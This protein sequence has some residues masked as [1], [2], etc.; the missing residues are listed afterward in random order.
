MRSL[1]SDLMLSM[2][3]MKK[4]PG[5]TITIIAVLTLGVGANTAIFSVIHGVLLHPFPYRDSGRIVFISE[6]P[7][8]KKGQM[9]VT[10][11][12]YIDLR[13]QVQDFTDV[14]FASNRDFTLTKV[15]EPANL[16]GAL[17]SASA[18][19]LLGMHPLMGRTF[20]EAEDR[21]GGAPVCVL[22]AAAWQER[23]GGDPEILGK[24]LTLD[25]K[26]YTVV[27]V[28]PPQ[29]KFWAAQ[30]WLPV[31][32]ETDTELMRSRVIRMNTWAVG[33]LKAGVS[34]TEA[35]TE[36]GVIAKRIADQH[37]ESNEDVGM[38]A[39]PLS[40][41]V[42]DGARRPLYTLLGASGFV[43]L[44]ACANVA[45]L[46]LARANTRQREFA[47]RA[48]LGAGRGR[49]VSQILNE[50]LPLA[51]LGAGS[52]ILAAA[53]GLKSLLAI[54]PTDAIPAEAEI[55]VNVPV[56]VFSVVVCVVTMLL[57]SLLPALEISR[58][59]L[60]GTLQE[61][62]R[63]MGSRRTSR[64]RSTLI[65]SEVALS[66]ML[67]VGA[68]L[69]IR[70]YAKLQNVNPGFNA[71]NL[72]VATIQLPQ[73][74]YPTG[75][76]GTR[77]FDE[78]IE[79]MR[80]LPGVKTVAASNNGPFLGG[81][82][83]PLLTR[84]RSYTN[85]ND[86]Q[87]L[88]F[89]CV[90]GDY[91]EA[92][93]LRMVQGRAFQESDR[94]GSEPVIILNEA[95][96][97]RFLKEGNPIGQEVMLGLPA[98]LIKPGMLPDFLNKFQWARVVGVAESSRYYGLQG[99][100]VPAAYIPVGQSWDNPILRN[101][102]YVL[103]RTR[104]DPLLAA[105]DVRAIVSSIDPDQPIQDMTTMERSIG[106]SMRPNRFMMMLLGIFAGVASILAAVGIYGVVAWNVTQRTR[107]IGIRSA[108]GATHRDITRLIVGHSMRVV[109]IGLVVGLAG[110]LALTRLL[111]TM[112]FQTSSFDAVTFAAVCAALSA[113]A[114]LA[115]V[116]P[117]RRATRINPIVALRTD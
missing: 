98:N 95:A 36:L 53:W 116:L 34:L 80:K 85:I 74:R 102:M 41:S 21:P 93:G 81:P 101:T 45:N 6:T 18:W 72:L 29:F 90:S 63:G 28:M 14:A 4:F 111:E 44:I 78:V 24:E 84:G 55:S 106:D 47:I 115:C 91:F 5:F 75:A 17:V 30:V 99:D 49:I 110:S 96:V 114:L 10:Y 8:D 16:K 109:L 13:R 60:A 19:P 32:P 89:G 108:L 22:S 67:L 52:G 97:K 86:L 117:T 92:Q 1:L 94:S 105:H 65:A 33:R 64:L 59:Q 66:L 35:N 11:P 77:F 103:I 54:L 83:L 62:S 26:A 51:L 23:L 69:L 46:I 42:T 31:G 25:G 82:N 57:F 27:G 7:K 2:R 73:S 87:G 68:G 37:P 12:D 76:S 56:M 38:S 88:P 39:Q 40:A 79:R 9:P 107:E 43:L 71:E 70:S 104:G 113:V 58:G 61:G 20:T 3:L 100:L 112:L 15:K 48:A 50:S